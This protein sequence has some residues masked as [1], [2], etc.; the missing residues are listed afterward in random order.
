MSPYFFIICA[1]GL[2]AMIR[3]VE[4]QALWNGIKMGYQG[5]TITHLLFADDCLLFTKLDS[6]NVR[7]ILHILWEYVRISG[8]KINLLKSR[9]YCSANVSAEERDELTE[10]LG[11]KTDDCKGL[12]LGMPYMIGM[13]KKEIFSS[14]KEKVRS[15]LKYWRE[16]TLSQ[17]RKEILI[18]S[19]VRQ[20]PPILCHVLIFQK[21][22]AK[23]YKQ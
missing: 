15:K 9:A 3:R 2:S 20:Y 21:L 10:I 5:P 1:E 17:S 22:S 18:K 11:V 13:S 16:K 12:Y 14:V 6:Q 19:V 8:Q 7:T 4:R 23:S